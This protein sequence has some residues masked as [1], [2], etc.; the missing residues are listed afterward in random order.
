MKKLKNN[1]IEKVE[2]IE[3]FENLEKI[4]KNWNIWKYW[5]FAPYNNVLGICLN[6]SDYMS[7]AL[8]SV[9]IYR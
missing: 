3:N 9:T 2:K 6:I 5:N 1:K 4:E 8:I 7:F